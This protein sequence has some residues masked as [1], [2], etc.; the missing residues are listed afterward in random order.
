MLGSKAACL[1]EGH[2]GAGVSEQQ[3]PENSSA[4]DANALIEAVAFLRFPAGDSVPSTDTTD[5]LASI[6]LRRV[7]LSTGLRPE[8]TNVFSNM[9][10]LAVRAPQSFLDALSADADV[11][12]V[13][14]N[15]L[16]D[17]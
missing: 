15:T 13:Q 6:V 11:D 16:R 17:K 4:P 7:E 10:A 3:N 5:A 2:F 1:G 8:A 14:A 12:R 9:H